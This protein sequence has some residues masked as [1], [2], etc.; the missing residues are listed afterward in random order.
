MW[1]HEWLQQISRCASV[2]ICIVTMATRLES[3]YDCNAMMPFESLY[4]C[5]LRANNTHT[6][7]LFAVVWVVSAKPVVS[8]KV[9]A[10]TRSIGD[11]CPRSHDRQITREFKSEL[12][13]A[14]SYVDVVVL[15]TLLLNIICSLACTL[16]ARLWRW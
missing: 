7:K 12:K 10:I 3:C 5:F 4:V 15:A 1:M 6:S 13:S 14:S 11:G 9:M 2:Y 8:A 16:Q